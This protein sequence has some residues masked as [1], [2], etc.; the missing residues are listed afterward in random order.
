MLIQ[1]TEL[2]GLYCPT[3][4]LR[5]MLKRT[6]RHGKMKN[7]IPGKS[8]QLVVRLDK[9]SPIMTLKEHDPYW[10]SNLR[11]GRRNECTNPCAFDPNNHPRVPPNN[12]NSDR[13][14]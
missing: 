10:F 3:T 4:P 12:L 11:S 13:G 14:L 7:C 1:L 8:E 2:P 5:E 9:V 6:P